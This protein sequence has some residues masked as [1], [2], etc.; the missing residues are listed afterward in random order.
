[1]HLIN[2]NIGDYLNF[3]SMTKFFEERHNIFIIGKFIKVLTMNSR[4]NLKDVSKDFQ[5]K[6]EFLLFVD[7]KPVG[8]FI[9]V[10]SIP[11]LVRVD[12]KNICSDEKSRMARTE[13]KSI[14]DNLKC[15]LSL[16]L[17]RIE[18]SVA[19]SNLKSSLLGNKF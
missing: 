11:V 13:S 6:V 4:K 16:F 1:M 5:I 2:N 8:I 7:S 10:V 17:S 14:Q 19:F 15:M 9:L 18:S 12:F 3:P